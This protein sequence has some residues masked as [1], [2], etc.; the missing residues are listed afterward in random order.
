MA[1]ATFGASGAPSAWQAQHFAAPGFH[2]PW[3]VQH[4]DP[5]QVG[6]LG[7]RWA[8]AAFALEALH[9]VLLG[10]PLCGRCNTLFSGNCWLALGL[11]WAPGYFCVAGTAFGASGATFARQAQHVVLLELH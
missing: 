10:L 4:F 6:A 8:P 5:L 11:R 2:F 1:G 9:F 7:R 3:R